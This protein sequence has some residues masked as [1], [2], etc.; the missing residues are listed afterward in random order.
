MFVGLFF[1]VERDDIEQV[2]D[3]QLKVKSFF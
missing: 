2:N 1:V 3:F